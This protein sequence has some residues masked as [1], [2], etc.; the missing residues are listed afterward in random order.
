MTRRDRTAVRQ[1]P[2]G[3]LAKR[4]WRRLSAAVAATV[5]V[6]AGSLVVAASAQAVTHTFVID[7]LDATAAAAGVN[8]GNG[9]CETSAGTCTMRAALEESNA[10]NLPPGAIT[11]TV[12]DG[13]TGNI[14]ARDG[15]AFRMHNSSVNSW[16]NGAHFAV[17]APVVIDLQ[18]RVTMQTSRDTVSALFYINGPDVEFRNMTQILSGRTSLSLGP[19]AD[20]FV[21]DGGST[22]TDRDYYA[23]R[24]VLV[25]EGAKNITIRNY[26]VRGFYNAARTGI[27]L[28]NAQDATP[29]ENLRVENVTVTYP[30]GSTCSSS[31]GSGC[32]TD[33]LQFNP[34]SQNVVLDGFAF[35][36]SDVIGMRNREAFPFSNGALSSSVRASNIVIENNRFINVQGT[37][38]GA[39]SAFIRLPHGGMGGVNR[40]VGNEFVRASSG[41]TFAISWNGNTTAGNAGDLTIAD[42]FFDGY[43]GTSI[44]LTNTGDVAVERNT[45]G[46]RSASQPR[47]GVTEETRT[48]T[49]TL[50]SNITN[51]N[52]QVAT[53]YPSSDAQVLTADAPTG[54]V[55]ARSPFADGAWLC[56][57]VVDV[58]APTG[59]QAPS[60]DADLD[61]F[62]TADRTADVYLGR[63]SGVS[64]S[65]GVIRVD[66]PV[67]AVPLPTTEPG[68]TR[69]VVAVDPETGEATGYLRVQTR[70]EAG[71]SSQYSRLV[72]VSGNCRPQITIERTEGQN[73][74]TLARD[75]NFTITSTLPLD[76]ASVTGAALEISAEAVD[77]TIDAARIAPRSVSVEAVPGS[78]SRE[79]SVVVHVDDSA[80][81]HL[82]IPAGRV[83]GL[84][85]VSNPQPAVDDEAWV[86][87]TNPVVA[88]PAQFALVTGDPLGQQFSFDLRT[89]A[90]LPTAEL[91]FAS[92]LDQAGVDLGVSISD[93]S[94]V[95]APAATSSTP[96]RVTA[97]AGDVAAGTPVV[98]ASALS[99]DDPNY[100]RLVVPP[101]T[102]RLF[103]TDPTIRIDKRA[104]VGVTDSSSPERIMATGT[105]ALSGT[106]LTD[107]QAV[108]FVYTVTNVSA[109]DWATRLT[110]VVVTDS[111]TRLGDGGVI[112]TI[113][114]IEI[115]RSAALSSCASL[116][117]VDTTVGSAG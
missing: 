31:N 69:D 48:A 90:P 73:S 113:D 93:P 101:V 108:C 62:W 46:D 10:L 87:F 34:R 86:V 103:A 50:L 97:E 3:S 2:A 58:T 65:S 19:E 6:V 79:F 67:G 9:V 53:W 43:T 60:G 63:A 38:T 83:S 100:D 72:P 42:N 57:A 35:V 82:A 71:Q 78:S 74:P 98:I 22:N 39:N 25:R 20:G 88:R 13:L 17:T 96:I 105:E 54:T 99:S 5:A 81:V 104:F 111:D 24:F 112:G 47:P 12:A 66:L 28:V 115:G 40:I 68:A 56:P 32:F 36:S 84:G 110:G 37:G 29:V 92:S 14:D 94:A 89:G 64:G 91:R 106:R 8:V 114:Q 27:F 41:Q 11:I 45:F 95:I 77:E 80:R 70:T 59:A 109:D 23:E 117:P 30:S 4:R 76:P 16:D 21:L 18:N 1:A 107:G 102:A 15:T 44:A 52:G 55:V 49:P 51:A 85:G 116:I 61:I 75:L 7:S 26:E 33:L